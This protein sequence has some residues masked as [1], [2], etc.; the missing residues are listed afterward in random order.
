M[1]RPSRRTVLT[2][3]AIPFALVLALGASSQRLVD[4]WWPTFPHE[5]LSAAADGSVRLSDT[6]DDAKGTDPVGS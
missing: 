2:V 3:S 6:L 5:R 1:T 4:R